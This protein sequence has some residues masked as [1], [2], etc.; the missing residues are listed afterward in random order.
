MTPPWAAAPPPLPP[1][2][3]PP[4]P[5]GG[6]PSGPDRRP[7]VIVAVIAVI[8][9]VGI[10]IGVSGGGDDESFVASVASSTTTSTTEA[11][12]VAL[13]NEEIAREHGSAVWEVEATGCDE[14]WTGSAF[15]IDPNHLVTNFHVVVTDPTPTLINRNGDRIEGTVIG[16]SERPDVAVIR[17]EELLTSWLDW[18]PTDELAEG[19]RLVVLGYPAPD[20]DFT[21]TPGNVI[22]FQVRS[23]VREAI[24]SDAAID[25]GNSGGPALDTSGRV[26]GIVTEMA[27]NDGGFQLVP[28]I[29]THE[30]VS[31]TLDEIF[32]DPAT[33]E[34]DCSWSE[35]GNAPNPD[36]DPSPSTWDSDAQVYGDDPTL[37]RLWDACAGG[38]MDACDEL[39]WMS[40]EGSEYES[41]GD[42]CG[43]RFEGG[44]WCSE[45]SG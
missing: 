7:L 41:F 34:A 9:I 17:T 27:A 42:T 16:W 21:V 13:S 38:D 43:N 15:A 5:A 25:R 39:W 28:L 20:T 2:G 37:D 19:E 35:L 4:P 6:T 36:W 30:A 29:F 24:R 3:P 32:D 10:A 12:P 31:D 44:A 26:M 18:A 22:S 33:P 40:P 1:T 14:V 23:G 11:A 45:D 8:A